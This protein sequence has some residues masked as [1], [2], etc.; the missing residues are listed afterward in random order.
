MSK[1]RS[2]RE[3]SERSDIRA[4]HDTLSIALLGL[5]DRE[6]IQGPMAEILF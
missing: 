5:K 4:E 2:V 1:A 6:V 3:Y